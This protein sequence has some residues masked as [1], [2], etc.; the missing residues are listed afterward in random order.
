MRERLDNERRGGK[1]IKNTHAEVGQPLSAVEGAVK[2]MS[3]DV[4]L[5]DGNKA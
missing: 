1:K 3:G 2:S 4:S 5:M